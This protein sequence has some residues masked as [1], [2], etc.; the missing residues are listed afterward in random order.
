[1]SQWDGNKK[2]LELRKRRNT[3]SVYMDRLLTS[4]KFTNDG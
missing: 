3:T 2:S 4:P 1:M